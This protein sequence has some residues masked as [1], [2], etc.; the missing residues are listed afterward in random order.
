MICWSI[1]W[2]KN[3]C[4]QSIRIGPGNVVIYSADVYGSTC[5][6][7]LYS[8]GA[9]G[10]RY[11]ILHCLDYHC[12]TFDKIRFCWRNI[13]QGLAWNKVGGISLS[14]GYWIESQL[15]HQII[16]FNIPEQTIV[17]W[18][19]L[20]MISNEYWTYPKMGV[21]NPCLWPNLNHIVIGD[22]LLRASYGHGM[23][24]CQ[25]S[26]RWKVNYFYF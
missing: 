2:T 26:H 23:I 13:D 18:W 22:H 11:V 5:L 1:D 6:M 17:S 4:Y 7:M 3:L 15:L 10:H 19:T 8:V 20:R 9:G 25:F 14:V 24:G 12:F 16:E 21:E